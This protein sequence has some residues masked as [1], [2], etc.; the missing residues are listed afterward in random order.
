MY[1]YYNLHGFL[2]YVVCVIVGAGGYVKPPL[3]ASNELPAETSIT[4][5]LTLSC[6]QQVGERSP[7]RKL[8]PSAGD[9]SKRN[10]TWNAL[11]R[12]LKHDTDARMAFKSVSPRKTVTLSGESRQQEGE[13]AQKLT[14]KMS[15]RYSSV[16]RKETSS[17]RIAARFDNPATAGPTHMPE[18]F[19][20]GHLKKPDQ[21]I[22]DKSN[23]NTCR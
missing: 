20:L 22:N 4:T 14:D 10:Q 19:D 17:S 1:A 6:S 8:L 21:S 7:T 15:K 12:D 9:R 11:S 16:P 5:S 3:D 13:V 23:R 2:Y 18:A